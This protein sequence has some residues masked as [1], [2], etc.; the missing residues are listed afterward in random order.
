MACSLCL[1][2]SSLAGEKLFKLVENLWHRAGRAGVDRFR[3]GIKIV[4]SQQRLACGFLKGH[5]G[6]GLAGVTLLVGPNEAR[7]RVDGAGDYRGG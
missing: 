5:R 7:R 2:G 1:L 6:D 4:H 3:R